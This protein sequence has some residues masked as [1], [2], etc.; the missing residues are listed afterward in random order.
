MLSKT[1]R[2]AQLVLGTLRAWE[3]FVGVVVVVV[4]SGLVGVVRVEEE[5]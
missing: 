2:I 5:W 4:V 3:V 1:A